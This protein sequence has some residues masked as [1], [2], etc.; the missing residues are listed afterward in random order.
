MAKKGKVEVRID[1]CKGCG[2]CIGSCKF[3]AIAL[4]DIS[5]T[6]AYGY[7]YMI[8]AND[9]CTGCTMCAIMCPDQAID[10]YRE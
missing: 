7:Q 8:M 2:L 9:K 3:G 6:N 4:T 10:V 5:K 1:H